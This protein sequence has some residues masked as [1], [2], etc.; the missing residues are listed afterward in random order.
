MRKKDIEAAISDGTVLALKKSKHSDY[1]P[2][3]VEGTVTD[4]NRSGWKVKHAKTGEYISVFREIGYHYKETYAIPS[5]LLFGTYEEVTAEQ[6][7]A[8]EALEQHKREQEERRRR[9]KIEA[10]ALA[11]RVRAAFPD[12]NVTTTMTI[13]DTPVVSLSPKKY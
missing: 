9:A 10:K 3:I 6:R 5:N 2:V 13:Y 8:Q 11:K 7:R 4:H 12:C 1:V